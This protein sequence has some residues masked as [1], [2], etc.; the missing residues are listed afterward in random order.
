MVQFTR[1]KKKIGHGYSLEIIVKTLK[2]KTTDKQ[3]P[4]IVSKCTKKIRISR[5]GIW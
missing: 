4:N 5:V 1:K 2:D 3:N